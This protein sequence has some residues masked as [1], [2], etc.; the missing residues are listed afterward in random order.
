MKN[1][2][3]YKMKNGKVFLAYYTNWSDERAQ[4]EADKLN[5]EKPEKLFNGEPVDWE[6]IEKFFVHKQEEMD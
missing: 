6:N 3:C 1:T 5:T 2:I 4:A